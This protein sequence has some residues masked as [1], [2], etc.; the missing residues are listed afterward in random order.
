MKETLLLLY[1]IYY[2]IIG[3]LNVK[4]CKEKLKKECDILLLLLD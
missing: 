1:I 4:R 3:I 2:L